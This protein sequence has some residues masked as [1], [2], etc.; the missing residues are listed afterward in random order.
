VSELPIA[1]YLVKLAVPAEGTTG[2]TGV[3]GVTT[4]GS[5]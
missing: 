5:T 3:V 4:V 2:V 1:T